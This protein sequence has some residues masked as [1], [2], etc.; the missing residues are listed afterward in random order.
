MPA[1]LQRKSDAALLTEFQEHF[2]YLLPRKPMLRADEIATATSLDQRTVIRLMEKGDL[3]GHEFNAGKDERTHRRYLRDSVILH[4]AKTATYTPADIVRGIVEVLSHRSLA[5][6]VTIQ[7]HLAA[8]IR[9]K[10][11]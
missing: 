11:S 6:L 8:L 1:A 2:D 4:L 3:H 10:Q 5:E 9:R 7:Q